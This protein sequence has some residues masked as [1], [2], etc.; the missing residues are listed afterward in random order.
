MRASQ[1]SSES[2][3]MHFESEVS[4][5]VRPQIQPNYNIMEMSHDSASK[6][7]SMRDDSLEHTSTRR[8]NNKQVLPRNKKS[9]SIAVSRA[10]NRTLSQGGRDAQVVK[11]STVAGYAGPIQTVIRNGQPVLVSKLGGGAGGARQ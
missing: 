5:E 7:G 11:G 6:S 8:S 4:F 2:N 9:S 3:N 1:I 10:S